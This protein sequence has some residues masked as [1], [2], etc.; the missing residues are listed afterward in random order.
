MDFFYYWYLLKVFP[1]VRIVRKF[2]N[3][4]VKK[5]MK[6]RTTILKRI[7]LKKMVKNWLK[8]VEIV[9]R[10]K[11]NRQVHWY[12]DKYKN[13]IFMI[14]EVLLPLHWYYDPVYIFH[15]LSDPFSRL[16]RFGS[17]SDW[18]LLLVLPYRI[19]WYII[20]FRAAKLYSESYE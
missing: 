3:L 16:N 1:F 10:L 2:T 11:W 9:K 5:Y 19:F 15:H 8:I 4:C 20:P 12:T 6:I 14:S 13:H 17:L 7:I 18:G